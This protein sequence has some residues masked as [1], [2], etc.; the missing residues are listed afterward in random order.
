MGSVRILVVDDEEDN[1]TLLGRALRRLGHE[2]VLAFHPVDAI[3]LLDASIDAVITDIHMPLMDGVRLAEAVR[4]VR[5]DVPIAF[6]TGSDPSDSMVRRATAYGA[7]FGKL[8][9]LDEVRAVLEGMLKS[10][11]PG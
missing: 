7:V 2:A 10:R 4:R 9:K 6:C 3:H 8:W 5:G 1:A 11:D